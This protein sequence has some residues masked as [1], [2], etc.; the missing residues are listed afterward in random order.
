LRSARDREQPRGIGLKALRLIVSTPVAS[1]RSGS[2]TATPM[3]LVPR[4]EADQPARS[5]QLRLSH[6]SGG[7]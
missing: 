4:I 1:R 6:R 3:V 7:G 5:G 2:E